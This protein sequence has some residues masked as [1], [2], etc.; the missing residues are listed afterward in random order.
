MNDIANLKPTIFCAVPRIF[1]RIYDKIK[2]GMDKATGLK[3]WLAKTALS[4]KL[5]NLKETGSFVSGCWDCL[6]FNK[7]KA[8]LGGNVRMMLTGSAPIAAEVL[9]LLKVCFCA[10]MFQGYVLTETC[11][12]MTMTKEN[13]PTAASHCG[14][15]SANTKIR[16]KDLPEMGYSHSNNPP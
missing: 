3:G 7:I 4:S 1:N 5:N 2:I 8:L 12:G 10:E 6:V 13:D 16:L 11:G 15:S 9:D 14:C